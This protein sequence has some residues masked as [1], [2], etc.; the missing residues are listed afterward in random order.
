M[1]IGEII[2]TPTGLAV[3]TAVLPQTLNI[4]NQT[5]AEVVTEPLTGG[6]SVTPSPPSPP[7]SI[8]GGGI[9]YRSL[10]AQ[11]ATAYV[12]FVVEETEA[13]VENAATKSAIATRGQVLDTL[14]ATGSGGS[15][16]TDG[17]ESTGSVPSLFSASLAY[18]TTQSLT[19]RTSS[20]ITLFG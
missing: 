20:T 19:R 6:P 18:Q 5:L 9:P 16:S 3:V 8:P 10:E 17:T 11:A 13:E 2:T 12:A 15:G 14:G 1:S 7:S 4:G